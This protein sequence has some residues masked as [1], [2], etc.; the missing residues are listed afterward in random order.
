MVIK[1]TTTVF[2]LTKL[3]T[4]FYSSTS[5]QKFL[6]VLYNTSVMDPWIPNVTVTNTYLTN[7]EKLAMFS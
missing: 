4:L 6:N 3:R 2:Y 5:S 1:Q 7:V